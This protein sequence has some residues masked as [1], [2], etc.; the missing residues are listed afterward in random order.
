MLLY[1]D[2]QLAGA[3][4]LY[5]KSHSRGEY[6]FDHAWAHAFQQYGLP[7]YPKLLCAIPFTPVPGPRLLAHTDHDKRALLHAAVTLADSNKLSSLHVLFPYGPD[8]PALDEAGFMVRKNVQF[9]WHNQNYRNMD[10]FLA[11]MNQR[12]RKKVRQ[13]RRKLTEEGVSFLWKEGSDIDD[14]TL[15]FFY[16]CYQQTYLEHGN[17]PYLNREFFDHLR[18]TM[19]GNLV[20][21]LACVG[22]QPVASALNLR[23]AN[24]LYGR[25][26]GSTRFISGLH[27]E[28]CYMQ[29]IEYSIAREL[30]VFEGGAQGEHKLARGL[31]PVQ[32]HSAH[33]V[34]DPQYSQAIRDFLVREGDMIESYVDELESHSPFRHG[35]T[36]ET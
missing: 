20:I 32:T 10:D 7:Y 29:G 17:L 5:L 33:W 11:Q 18:S 21:I 35:E 14:S 27:F 30:D 26:W 13:S 34:R 16:R 2:D 31:M 8:M 3:M 28:T 9:H 4:P 24:R 25:Y 6:V 12:N 23:N 15:D 36:N 22:D 19:A 1:R